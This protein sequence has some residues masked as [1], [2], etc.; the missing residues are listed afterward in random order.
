MIGYIK[1]DTKK[2]PQ[3][4]TLLSLQQSIGNKYLLESYLLTVSLLNEQK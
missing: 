2:L 3:Y 1:I 4:L